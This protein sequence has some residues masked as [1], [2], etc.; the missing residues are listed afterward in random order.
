MD[1]DDHDGTQYPNMA[2]QDRVSLILTDYM[3]LGIVPVVIPP[4]QIDRP[5]STERIPG[6]RGTD[7]EYITQLA[8]TVGHVFFVDPGPAPGTSVAYWGPK[9]KVSP[10]QPALNINMDAHTNVESLSFS[11]EGGERTE[12]TVR[13]QD[14]DTKQFID[15]PVP[16]TT[17]LEPPLGAIPPLNVK[18]QIIEASKLTITEAAM[19]ALSKASELTDAVTGSGSL[20]VVR[21]GGILKARQLVGVRGA[22]PAFDGLHYVSSVTH[23]IK[24]GEYKQSF[25]LSRNGLL[26]TVPLVPS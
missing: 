12:F 3:N 14:E 17:L 6:Q 15:V 16:D 13:V 8:K 10:P 25:N 18:K 9:V 24:P 23:N 19:L 7:L 20:D 1:Q 5:I 11:F 26:S 21:Y 2:V 4:L 22:G